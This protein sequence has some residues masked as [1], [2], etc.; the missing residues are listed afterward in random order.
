MS[1]R[2]NLVVAD[3]VGEVLTKL[4]GSERARGAWVSKIALAYAETGERAQA[5]SLDELRFAFAGLMAEQKM[6]EARILHLEQQ[7][8]ALIAAK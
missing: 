4:A 1:E 5:N 8:A 6:S 3:G 7:V 2:L